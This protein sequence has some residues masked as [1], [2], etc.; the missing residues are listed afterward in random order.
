MSNFPG[1]SGRLYSGMWNPLD[2]DMVFTGGEDSCV[3]GWRVSKQIHSL[4]NKK[5]FKKATLKKGKELT[6]SNSTIKGGPPS[7]NNTSGSS[8]YLTLD[9]IAALDAKRRELVSQDSSLLTDE[10]SESMNIL[11]PRLNGK[12]SSFSFCFLMKRFL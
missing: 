2:K 6:P 11:E 1:H 7:S 4:P 12:E 5:V 9:V 10:N 8:D 3:Y